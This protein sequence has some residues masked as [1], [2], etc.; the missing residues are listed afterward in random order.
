MERIGNLQDKN[1]LKNKSTKTE[2]SK[3]KGSFDNF[4]Y[5]IKDRKIREEE[6]E[7]KFLVR[8]FI[9]LGLISEYYFFKIHSNFV[10][11]GFGRFR[12]KIS[13]KKFTKKE[14]FT[15]KLARNS[16][17]GCVVKFGIAV[18]VL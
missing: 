3:M 11:L 12:K 1:C 10:E 14:K 5:E 8:S 16:L 4:H 13:Q 15:S 6:M 18:I 17:K 7:N 9:D 2:G